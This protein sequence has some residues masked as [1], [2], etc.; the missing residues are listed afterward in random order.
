MPL[1]SG[2]ALTSFLTC[3]MS[4][5][6]SSS[7]TGIISIPNSSQQVKCRSYPGTGQ[8]NLTGVP[9]KEQ[10]IQGFSPPVPNRQR[11][12]KV[13][14]IRF[15]LEL[16]PI[17]R[18]S[19]FSPKSRANSLLHSGIPSRM[20][21]FLASVPSSR[22]QPSISFNRSLLKSNCEGLGFPRVRFRFKFCL[23]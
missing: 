13:S 16:P 23:W 9:F 20:P 18:A 10:Y 7:G 6:S 14:N 22:R 2:S 4:G 21:Q 5:P 12:D 3:S 11:L 8:R 15:R 17:I 1:I 19:S